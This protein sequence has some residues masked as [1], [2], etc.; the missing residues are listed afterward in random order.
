MYLKRNNKI[1]LK[2]HYN[3]KILIANVKFDKQYIK[4]FKVLKRVDK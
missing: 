2:L 3:Y 1:Y 4:S